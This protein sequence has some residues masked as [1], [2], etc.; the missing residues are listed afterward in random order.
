MPPSEDCLPV[1]VGFYCHEALATGMDA[2]CVL[3]VWYIQHRQ[4]MIVELWQYNMEGR[5]GNVH[6]ILDAEFASIGTN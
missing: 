4:G 1:S 3:P 5:Y 6:F 2:V